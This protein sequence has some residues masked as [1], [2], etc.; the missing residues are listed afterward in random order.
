MMPLSTALIMGA[1]QTIIYDLSALSSFYLD[2]GAPS[3]VYA[4]DLHF[5]VTTDATVD[6]LRNINADL[7]NEAIYAEPAPGGTLYVRCTQ[8]SGTALN[9]GDTLGSW[10]SLTISQARN[11]GLSYMSGG[12]PDL[13]VANIDLEIAADAAGTNIVASKLSISLEVGE[14]A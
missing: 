14:T 12:G 10:L 8:N 9:L 13:A 3:T 5:R 7:L 2:Q 1:G 4:V 11:F 6:I